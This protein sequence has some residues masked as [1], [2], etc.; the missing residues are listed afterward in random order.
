MPKARGQLEGL[1]NVGWGMWL[2]GFRKWAL[3]NFGGWTSFLQGPQ[4]DY[5][6]F[7]V[8]FGSHS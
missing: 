4:L 3:L 5:I 2:R 7:R 1:P 8:S 6:P